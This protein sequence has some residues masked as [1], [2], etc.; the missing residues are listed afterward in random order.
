MAEPRVVAPPAPGS[1]RR[2]PEE[3][4]VR[5]VSRARR[6]NRELR[7]DTEPPAGITKLA[8]TPEE[9]ER[10]QASDVTIYA[11]ARPVPSDGP[12]AL[13]LPSCECLALVW[14]GGK[15]VDQR[16]QADQQIGREIA[17]DR[18][19][20]LEEC[21]LAAAQ[22]GVLAAERLAAEVGQPHRDAAP[23]VL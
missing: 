8:V 10:R 3:R 19:Q 23:I 13:M 1:T 17:L 6:R 7:P 2:T 15:L 18:W 22:P 12:V 14:T 16:R 11:R 20:S 9:E 21:A 4:G 5:R